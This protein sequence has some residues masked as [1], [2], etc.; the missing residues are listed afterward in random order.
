MRSPFSATMLKRAVRDAVAEDV[1]AALNILGSG[2]SSSALSAWLLLLADERGS[3]QLAQDQAQLVW[4]GPEGSRSIAR[5]T[6]V[7][8][9]ELF[10]SAQH[11]IDIASYAIHDGKHI[12]EELAQRMCDVPALRVRMFLHIHRAWNDFQTPPATLLNAF[13]A[14]FRA[15][16][17]PNG[18]AL[19]TI[20]YDPRT[21]TADDEKRA[22]LHAKV[23]VVDSARALITSANLTEAA[24]RRNIEAGVLV[25]NDTIATSLTHQ[26]DSLIDSGDLKLI[27]LRASA[28]V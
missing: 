5:D 8:M 17:W 9:T 2:L 18:V 27:P 11:T 10:R 22:S 24:Q 21:V 13:A 12:L 19:P 28:T 16:H 1:A 25:A 15:K 14:D 20:Y 23:V 4:T 26:F 6:W 7:T 3:V